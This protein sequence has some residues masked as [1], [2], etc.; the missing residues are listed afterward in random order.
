[1]FRASTCATRSFCEASSSSTRSF[2]EASVSSC[3]PPPISR[4]FAVRN[5]SRAFRLADH[6][7]VRRARCKSLEALRPMLSLA[8]PTISTIP[9]FK[10]QV[11]VK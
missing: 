10:H 3:R 9:I 1:M 7:V 11:S 6:L 4:H 2:Y 5:I 8:P